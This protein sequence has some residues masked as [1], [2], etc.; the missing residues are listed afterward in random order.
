MWSPTCTSSPSV[1]VRALAALDLGG[2]ELC[3]SDESELLLDSAGGMRHA[4]PM[5][6]D[7]P[8][9]LVNG[10]VLCDVDLRALGRAHARLRASHGV[11]MTLT[12]F[13]RPPF[14]GK[15]AELVVQGDRV[16]EWRPPVAGRPFFVGA[17]VIEPEALAHLPDSVPS[18]F[19][20]EVL[21][22][23]ITRGRVG[24]FMT[25]GVWHDIGNPQMW[26]STHL[27]LIRALETGRIF[28]LWRRRIERVNKRVAPGVWIPLG[29]RTPRLEDWVGPLYFHPWGTAAAPRVLG[30]RSVVYGEGGGEDA[31]YFC[32]ATVELK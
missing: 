17:A 18:G 9:Y 30:P 6:G 26:H 2:A 5:L 7:G 31:I 25:D 32:G 20:P 14:G 10:D 24:A 11:V 1:R 27:A 4:L 28:P 12:I 16:V 22:P 21:K 29:V 8:F 3:V 13:P 19:V 15:Y 23:E